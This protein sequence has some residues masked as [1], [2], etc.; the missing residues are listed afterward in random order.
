MVLSENGNKAVGYYCCVDFCR[1]KGFKSTFRSFVRNGEKE[2]WAV[3]TF[4]LVGAYVL[5]AHWLYCRLVHLIR[6]LFLNA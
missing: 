4:Y 3:Q 6:R 1:R 5:P 2:I